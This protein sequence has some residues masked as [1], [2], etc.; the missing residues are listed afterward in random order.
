MS[1]KWIKFG[2]VVMTSDSVIEAFVGPSECVEVNIVSGV[3]RSGMYK[4]IVERATSSEV[5][6]HPSLTEA[7]ERLDEILNWLNGED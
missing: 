6:Y 1:K 2:G 3:T 7:E 4:V 5:E